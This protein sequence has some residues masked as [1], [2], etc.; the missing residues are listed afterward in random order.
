MPIKPYH[1]LI[2]ITKLIVVTFYLLFIILNISHFTIWSQITD[3]LADTT[4]H[5]RLPTVI[6]LFADH[7]PHALRTSF[8][9]PIYQMADI[10]GCDVTM[11]YSIVVLFLFVFMYQI[12]VTILKGFGVSSTFMGLFVILF[13]L[14]FMMHG[15]ISF[16]MFGNS[17]IL[18]TL[19]AKSYASSP[20][21]FFK[22]LFLLFIALWCTSVSSGTFMVALGS[23]ITFYSIQLLIELPYIKKI[24]LLLFTVLLILLFLLSPI[25]IQ[26][27][28][29]NLDFYDGS[30]IHML[31]HGMGKYILKYIYAI[32]IFI[33]VLP[34][35]VMK[36]LKLLKK[37]QHFILPI[38]MIFA[39]LTI[40][41]FGISSLV[42]GFPAY[43]VF[44]Y[45]LL[46]KRKEKVM[47]LV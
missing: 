30:F 4:F 1:Q 39:S 5:D 34:F 22:F 12:L 28:N 2:F 32:G 46:Y 15:R 8:I 11:F 44:L 7:H 13:T 42:S 40:G 26:F 31:D 38:S 29:K 6:Q 14:S 17:L 36:I 3:I 45:L 23:I 16:A 37:D 41:L 18:Y 20:I 35:F 33:L 9:F 27:V 19:Y 43:I 25:I 21:G 10:L 47:H 24:Y